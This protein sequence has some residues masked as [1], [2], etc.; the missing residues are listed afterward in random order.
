MDAPWY[1]SL[2]DERY[3]SFYPVL[4]ERPVAP[5][6]A[7]AA[8]ALLELDAGARVL[9]LGC[10]TGRHSVALAEAGFDVTGLDLS[11]PLLAAARAT[12][13]ARGCTVRWICR[14]MRDLQ[15]LGPFDA[16]LCLYTAFG[17]FGD[18]EDQEVLMQVAAALAPRGQ[19]LLDVTNH[20]GYLR[21]FPREV[22]RE[23]ADAVLCERN[24]YEPLSGVLVTERLRFP[25]SGGREALPPSRVRAYLPHELRAMLGRAGLHVEKLYG[26]LGGSAFEWAASPCQVFCCRRT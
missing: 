3:L 19:L 1:E 25:R 18:V 20:L 22:W 21:R 11:E 14:D 13:A 16:C 9:D 17:F 26:S 12:A 2:F 5:E 8:A 4:R 24:T 7:Q 10:G 15:D 23:T 6:E